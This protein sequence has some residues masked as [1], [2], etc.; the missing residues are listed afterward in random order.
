[1]YTKNRV[2]RESY[3]VDKYLVNIS[4]LGLIFSIF[5]LLFQQH[6]NKTLT[7]YRII[8]IMSQEINWKEKINNKIN[9]KNQQK[10]KQKSH[11]PTDML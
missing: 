1:M 10:I 3:N 6:V 4:S 8:G 5:K 7:Y 2:H 11:V 9:K